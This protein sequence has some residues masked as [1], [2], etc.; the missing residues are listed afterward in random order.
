MSLRTAGIATIKENGKLRPLLGKTLG[1]VA[2]DYDR[3]GW[4]DIAVCN[5]RLRNFLFHNRQGHFE[6]VGKV[7]NFAFANS[8]AERAGM[9]TDAADT[10]HSAYESLVV[11]N[12]DQE[13]LGLFQNFGG[14]MFWDVALLSDAGQASFN[15]LTFGCVFADFDNDTWT[16]VVT[17]NGHIQPGVD[18][19]RKDTA[20]AQT[21]LLLK[22]IG[23]RQMNSP[24]S[25][26]EK[27]S[28]ATFTE[29]PDWITPMPRLVGRG[30]A[31]ADFDRD[32]DVDLIF[33]S[34]GGPSF[35]LRNDSPTMGHSLR[36]TLSASG[37]NHEAIGA[38][39][40]VDLDK[41]S[42]RR[43]VRAGHSYVSQSE[44]PV[45]IGLGAA[46]KVNSLTVRWPSGKTSVF[47]NV[48]ADRELTIS[49]G[50]G[51]TH[52]APLKTRSGS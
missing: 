9:G 8:G 11:G 52:Q 14:K 44:L 7:A 49:E 32:G 35:L 39:I 40:W 29:P 45:T 31:A 27:F 18:G 36:V 22:N 34:N 3:D 16:D 28:Y 38:V 47:A 30:L 33:T 15:K 21:P 24:L 41:V 10:D 42:L 43:T 46:Q 25:P 19:M 2:L 37:K 50:K 13:R 1:A 6:E 48:K 4:M 26:N 5:D 20:H 12:F 23:P 51:I 17:A